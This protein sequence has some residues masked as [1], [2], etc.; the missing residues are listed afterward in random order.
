[1]QTNIFTG[2]RHS[3]S[4]ESSCQQQQAGQ[5]EPYG[6]QLA[7]I[8]EEEETSNRNSVDK[9]RG[10]KMYCAYVVGHY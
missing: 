7:R 1:M 6:H 2:Y 8:Q 9:V 10:G 3:F 5:Y 4:D